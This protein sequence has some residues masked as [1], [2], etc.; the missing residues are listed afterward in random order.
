MKISNRL[1]TIASF[2]EDDSYVFDVGCDHA[3][4]DIFL[5]QNKKNIKVVASDINPNPLK[6]A[7]KNI[8]LYGVSDKVKIALG[9]GLTNIPSSVD[10]IIISGLGGL[11]I[12]DIFKRDI[13]KLANI[14]TIILSP[15]SDIYSV[16]KYVTSIGYKIVDE[17]LLQDQKKIYTV[18]KFNKGQ[19]SYTE[20]ELL[21]GPIIL[22]NKT[23]LFYQYYQSLLQKNKKIIKKIPKTNKKL[24][25]EL[26]NINKRLDEVLKV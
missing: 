11:T 24:H 18:I 13:D 7:E 5:V 10:T 9:D 19:A 26:E 14:K 23:P 3:L 17:I 4:L 21:F 22:Q 6:F 20:D 15:H 16:R 25:E 1:K 8:A 2:V 12:N